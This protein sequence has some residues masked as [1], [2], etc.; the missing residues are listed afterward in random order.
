MVPFL[1]SDLSTDFHEP[2]NT[3][4]HLS[5]EIGRTQRTNNLKTEE[6]ALFYLGATW[7]K[8]AGRCSI[9][10]LQPCCSRLSREKLCRLTNISS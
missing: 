5:A 9:S 8:V 10:S 1:I 7:E 6:K 3:H 2:F 4:H